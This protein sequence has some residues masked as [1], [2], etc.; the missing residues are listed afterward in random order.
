M[1][2]VPHSPEPGRFEGSAWGGLKATQHGQP[3]VDGGMLVNLPLD[4][5]GRLGFRGVL[6]AASEGGYIDD[7]GRG[8]DDVNDVRTFGGRA[9]LRFAPTED[10]T[11][12]L[13]LVGQRI[14]GDDS[15]YAERD[16]GG[17]TRSSSIAQPYSNDFWLTDLTARKDWGS[18]EFTGSLAYAKQDV[19]EQFE[20]VTLFDKAN[21][22]AAPVDLD[23][24]SAYTQ[25]NNIDMLTVEARLAQ[26]DRDG[27]GWLAGVS[28]LHNSGKVERTMGTSDLTGVSNK[29]EEAT[30]YGEYAFRPARDVTVTVGGRL[31]H[32]ALSGVAENPVLSSFLLLDPQ[33]GAKRSET[34]LLPS[35]ALAYLAHDRLTLFARYQQSFRPGGIAVRREFIQRFK[36]D[37]VGTAEAGLRYR[38]DDFDLSASGSWTQWHHIQ[39]DL[40]DGFGFPITANI[41]NG[42]VYSL[43]A[44]ANLRPADGLEFDLALYLNDSRLTEPDMLINQLAI[45]A[46]LPLR[47]SFDRLPNVAD[48]SA[49]AGVSYRTPVSADAALTIDGYVRYVGQSTL[50]VGSILGQLQGDYL[51]TGLEIGLVDGSRSYSLSL[52]NLFDARGNRFALGSPFLV[53]D[54]NQITPLQPRSIRIGLEQR[55]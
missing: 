28:L 25:S 11:I 27:T 29:I 30:L 51:D 46:N 37:K 32:S 24:I 10:W 9:A 7:T 16:S 53:R 35:V 2:V 8:L 13:N 33:A 4:E 40:I 1:R 55:F 52:T 19:V 47:T 39:A 41:G 22:A 45:A 43:G 48:V 12:D 42:R 54:M 20:G 21:S 49:R 5:D 31:A 26:R 18:L 44:S 38:G 6:F 34:R 23:A 3:G 15:Q 14:D 50:G 17:L 36:S